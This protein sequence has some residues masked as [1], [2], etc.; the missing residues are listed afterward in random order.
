MKPNYSTLLLLA[1]ASLFG[2]I[3]SHAAPYKAEFEEDAI[4]YQQIERLNGTLGTGKTCRTIAVSN[5][6]IYAT[7]KELDCIWY[8]TG[9]GWFNISMPTGTNTSFLFTT[10]DNGN[11]IVPT[12]RQYSWTTSQFDM[13]FLLLNP[14]VTDLHSAKDSKG[15]YVFVTIPANTFGSSRIDFMSASGD[16]KSA[17]GGYLY[18]YPKDGDDAGK[19]IRAKVAN[20]TFIGIE[21]YT[22]GPTPETYQTLAKAATDADGNDQVLIQTGGSNNT[23]AL[24]ALNTTD[25][26][27]T[28]VDDNPFTSRFLAATKLTHSEYGEYY[29]YPS[30]EATENTITKINL[31]IKNLKTGVV[32]SVALKYDGTININS[33]TFVGAW[34]EARFD[35]ASHPDRIH[36]YCFIPSKGV[37]KYR[38]NLTLSKSDLDAPNASATIVVGKSGD[39]FPGR[40][41]AVITWDALDGAQSYRVERKLSTADENAWSVVA[42]NLTDTTFTDIDIIE[43]YHYRVI[44][45]E[46]KGETDPSATLLCEPEFIPHKPQFVFGYIHSGYAAN[47]LSWYETYGFMPDAY[48]IIRD[49][50]VIAKDITAWYYLDTNVPEGDR[51]YEIASVYYT[52]KAT[53]TRRPESASERILYSTPAR[54]SACEMYGIAELYNYEISNTSPFASIS[55]VPNFDDQNLYRQA[56]FYN[57]KW[58]IAQRNEQNDFSSRD[59]NGGIVCFDANAGSL[60]SMISS[61][62]KIYEFEGNVNVGIA[63]DDNGTF[64]IKDNDGDESPT[65]MSEYTHPLKKGRLLKFNEDASGNITVANNVSIDLSGVI[66]GCNSIN[67]R[68]DYYSMNGDVLNGSGKLYIAPSADATNSGKDAWIIDIANGAVTTSKYYTSHVNSNIGGTDNFLF[69]LDERDDAIHSV[70]SVGYFRLNPNKPKE[71]EP[72]FHFMNYTDIAGGTSIWFNNELFIITPKTLYSKNLGDFLVAKGKPDPNKLQGDEKK[73][74]NASDV[75]LSTMIPIAYVPQNEADQNSDKTADGMWFGLEPHYKTDGTASYLDIYL[76]VPAIRFAKYRL[77]PYNNLSNPTVD[78]NVDIQYQTDSVG[79]NID[80]LSFK[81]TATWAPIADKDDMS[82]KSYYLKFMTMDNAV[83]AEHWFDKDGNELDADGNKLASV[84][85]AINADGLFSCSIDNLDNREYQAQL[86]AFF[87]SNNDNITL[88]S[89]PSIATDRT[90]YTAKAPEGTIRIVTENYVWTDAKNKYRR[91]HRLDIDFNAP[92]FSATGESYPVSYYELWYNM[93]GDEAGTYPHRLEGFTLMNGADSVIN[94]RNIIPGTFDFE[95]AKSLVIQNE[96]AKV[97]CYYFTRPEVEA[98]GT[99]INENDDPAKWEFIVRA[100]YA[101]HAANAAIAK[102][103][104]SVL[105]AL[106]TLMTGV[107]EIAADAGDTAVYPTLT[108]GPLTIRANEPI[109]IVA[110]YSVDGSLVKSFAGNSDSMLNIDLSNLQSGLYIVNVNNGSSHKIVKR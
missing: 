43:A 84:E 55:A 82:F 76:Y 1:A 59:L 34:V 4:W 31:N 53:K 26:T 72:I 18:F 101:A 50:V 91:N 29:V 16:L 42:N 6:K 71:Y 39:A 33:D 81:G 19:L 83:I 109:E 13:K 49:G 47:E 8:T 67:T 90:D 25:K 68:A 14:G 60:E 96:G 62:K 52:D 64:F 88:T 94:D 48:D 79:T 69:P 23:A 27:L 15:D 9:I 54:D 104:Q 93:P 20:S 30:Y 35:D 99:L 38:V 40:Q 37:W 107:E 110:V 66:D 70:G 32:D 75:L 98:D 105:T 86:T 46:P 80:I 7:S 45:I 73:A 77:Y 78:M 41:D 5:S 56:A 74:E 57:G 2:T 87:I 44:A 51:N 95:N 22:G 106:P 3:S 24:Y 11:I 92:D 36:V 102:D 89:E 97:V 17:D 63:V 108:Y 21:K 10:D 85:N 61:A 103:S 28:L 58:Y 100:K 65:D 12:S